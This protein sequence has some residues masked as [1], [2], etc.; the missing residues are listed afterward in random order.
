MTIGR[1]SG[2]ALRSDL[3]RQ[4]VDLQF[5][6]DDSP[7]ATRPPG[8]LRR[9]R[10]GLLGT[11]TE[12]RRQPGSCPGGNELVCNRSTMRIITDLEGL[13]L[14]MR[15]AGYCSFGVSQHSGRQAECAAK[16]L[17]LATGE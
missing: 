14:G 16:L 1:I 17:H 8:P 2:P 5:S 4:G 15:E 11:R 6:T 13:R 9:R 7:L 12:L 10:R 3:D